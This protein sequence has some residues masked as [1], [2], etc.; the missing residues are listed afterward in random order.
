M[1]PLYARIFC[2]NFTNYFTV[3]WT[4]AEDEGRAL[5]ALE[6]RS[7][8]AVTLALGRRSPP[9]AGTQFRVAAPT[10]L[11]PT[12]YMSGDLTRDSFPGFATN[13]NKVTKGNDFRLLKHRSHYDLRKLSFT[14]RICLLYTSPSPRD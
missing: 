3:V 11:L 14:N 9:L 7:S 1:K 4:D 6:S 2:L 12:V 8:V 13:I 10:D 5:I